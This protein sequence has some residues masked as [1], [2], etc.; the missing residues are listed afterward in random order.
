MT[1]TTT[2]ESPTWRRFADAPPPD[3]FYWARW[4]VAAIASSYT[5]KEVYGD[6]IYGHGSD[7]I[8]GYLSRSELEYFTQPILPPV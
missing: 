6:A 4:S 8:E 3:G 5:I 2:T 1:A 7:G